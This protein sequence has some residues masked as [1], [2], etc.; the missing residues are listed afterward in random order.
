M[1]AGPSYRAPNAD[2][3]TSLSAAYRR[4]KWPVSARAYPAPMPKPSFAE[5]EVR[6][7]NRVIRYRRTGVGR[8]VLLLHCPDYSEPL[9]PELIEALGAGFRLIVPDLPAPHADVVGWLGDFLEGLGMSSVR[10]LA[11][12]RFC[13]PALELTLLDPDQVAR[14]VLVLASG[15]LETAMRQPTVPILVVRRSQPADDVL[16]LV[17]GFLGGDA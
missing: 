12:D 9:W 13:M 7:H 1:I 8:A 17:T 14:V 6:A 4:R 5:A 2:G 3:V 11:A 10:I 16:P 15:S